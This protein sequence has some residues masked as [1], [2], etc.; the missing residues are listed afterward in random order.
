MRP[1]WPPA[2]GAMPTRG[3]TTLVSYIDPDNR[4]SIR[5]AERMGARRDTVAPGVDSAMS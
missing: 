1:P 2:A 3:L 4:R 5:L